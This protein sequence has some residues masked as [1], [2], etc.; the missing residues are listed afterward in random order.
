MSGRPDHGCLFDIASDQS[1]FFTADQA[2]IWGFN[3]RMLLYHARQGRFRHIRRGLYRL[4]DFPASPHEEVVAVWLAAGRASAVISHES[5][6]DLLDLADIIPD[7]IHLTAPRSR[8]GLTVPL[9]A[10]VHTSSAALRPDEVVMVDGIRVTAAARTII[11]V[12]EADLAPDQ[13]E[14]AVANA[15]ARGTATED[16][17]REQGSRRGRRVADQIDGVLPRVRQRATAGSS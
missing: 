6:L 7:A 1:G 15:L 17:L 3:W 13:V 8:R 11:D 12:T 5:A 10:R 14:R 9:G 16:E 2:H 4:R